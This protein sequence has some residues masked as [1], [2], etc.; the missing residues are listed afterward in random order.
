[1]KKFI[2]IITIL[3]NYVYKAQEKAS[4]EKS[5]TGVQ[6]N[7][8]GVN[9][10]NESRIDTEMVLRTEGSLDLVSIWGGDIYPKTGFIMIPSLKVSP[11]WYYNINKRQSEGRNIKNNAANFVNLELIYKPGGLAIS[12]YN[13]I[14][15]N[16][17]IFLIPNC[18]IRRNFSEHFNYEFNAGIGLGKSLVPGSKI[19]IVP[20]LNFRLGYDF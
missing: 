7:I 12:N 19:C 14:K 17:A 1:M 5:I 11:K 10:Y 3:V 4:V 15:V 18:G 2:I 6:L 20:S 8:V 13:D 9:I 16:D